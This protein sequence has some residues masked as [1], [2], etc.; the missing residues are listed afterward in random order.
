M[1]WNE[2]NIEAFIRQ[3]K[4]KFDKYDPSAYHNDHFLIKLHN[5]FKHIISIVPHLIKVFFVTIIM[6]I[7]SIYIWNSYIRKDRN[8]ITLKQKIENILIFKK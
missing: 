4:D 1:N 8:E 2:E 7:F 6:F 3:H 5:K